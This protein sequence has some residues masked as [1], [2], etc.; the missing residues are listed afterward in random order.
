MLRYD[1]IRKFILEKGKLLL[2][3]CCVLVL[4]ACGEDDQCPT[5]QE[6]SSPCPLC[7]F[8]KLLTKSARKI[9]DNSWAHLATGLGELVL[10][11]SA[12]YITLFTVRMVTSFGKQTMSEYLTND[13][14]GLFIFMFKATIIFL[15]LMSVKFWGVNEFLEYVIAP[16]LQAGFQIG[17]K[18][19]VVGDAI[20]KHA[21]YPS[22]WDGIFAMTYDAAKEFNDSVHFVV[23]LG[24]AMSC[25]AVEGLIWEWKF[26]Q[27]VYGSLLFIFGWMLLASVSFFLVDVIVRLTFGAVL[28]PVGIACAISKLSMPYAKNIWNLFVNVFFCVIMLGI[29]IALIIQMVELCVGVGAESPAINEYVF[30]LQTAMDENRI[31]EVSGAFAN[32]GHLL[33]TL[34]CFSIMLQLLEQGRKLASEISETSI[35]ESIS[36]SKAA[37]PLVKAGINAGKRAGKWAGNGIVRETKS[38]GGDIIRKTKLD[39]R[40]NW[41]RGTLFGRGP[42]GY[43]AWWRRL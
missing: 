18:V 3:L 38:I 34:V 21:S 10:V 9:A 7:K 13:K 36:P 12:I 25:N 29:L 23:G 43:R 28:L 41:V 5:I 35:A 37:A 14:M 20:L 19:S 16:L 40:Y 27:L 1:D 31:S 11:I 33:L 24:K 2:L 39:K 30:D 32:F 22:T 4:T 6:A 17:T 15:L 42:Q 26:L 8:F